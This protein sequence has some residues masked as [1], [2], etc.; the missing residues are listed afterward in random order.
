[1]LLWIDSRLRNVFVDRQI[2]IPIEFNRQRWYVDS[3]S[4]LSK[5]TMKIDI[6]VLNVSDLL[7]NKRD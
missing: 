6:V 5:H 7:D 2:Y 1:M 3:G 4:G